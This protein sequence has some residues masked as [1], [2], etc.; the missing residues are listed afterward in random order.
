MV[1]IFSSYLFYYFKK[2]KFTEK[3]NPNVTDNP[4]KTISVSAI[5]FGIFQFFFW[6][7]P[8]LKEIA[9][10]IKIPKSHLTNEI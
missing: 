8:K 4:N 7:I 3:F 10:K 1:F 2:F 6:F 9:K 5:K